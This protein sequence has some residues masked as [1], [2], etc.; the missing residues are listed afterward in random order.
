MTSKKQVLQKWQDRIKESNSNGQ[1][2]WALQALYNLKIIKKEKPK[3]ALEILKKEYEKYSDMAVAGYIKEAID[4]LEEL[5][6]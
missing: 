2:L 4:D 1:K 6:K 3:K 5:A